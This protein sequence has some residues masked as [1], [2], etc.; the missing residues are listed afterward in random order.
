MVKVGESGVIAVAFVGRGVIVSV[1]ELWVP[2]TDCNCSYP[3]TCRTTIYRVE[4]DLGLGR[5]ITQ[6]WDFREDALADL[7]ERAS[8]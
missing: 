3:D 1:S 8:S 2:I 5:T 7:R 4:T 6:D